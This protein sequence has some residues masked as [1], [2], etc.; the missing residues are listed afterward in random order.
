VELS[1][2]TPIVSTGALLSFLKIHLQEVKKWIPYYQKLW[3]NLK[4][5]EGKENIFLTHCNTL[6]I[7]TGTQQALGN[8]GQRLGKA[9]G[10]R[11]VG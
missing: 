11:R 6:I 4:L 5:D 10:Q 9:G 7:I 1:R 8:C 3:G 2:R